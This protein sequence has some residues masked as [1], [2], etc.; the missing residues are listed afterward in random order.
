MTGKDENSNYLLSITPAAYVTSSSE[1]IL[2]TRTT[3]HLCP[4][5]E[6]FTDFH[7]LESGVVVMGNDQPCR[8]MR[9]EIIRLKIFDGMVRELKEFRFVPTLKKI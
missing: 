7:N 9:I 1:W 8:T 6:W 4:I 5:K 2:D 3:Y